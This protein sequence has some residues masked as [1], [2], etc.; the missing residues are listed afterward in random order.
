MSLIVCP[1]CGANVSSLAAKCP[2]CGCVISD[3]VQDQIAAKG[4]GY[5]DRPITS[6]DFE[7]NDFSL[8]T[9]DK[10][11]LIP[12]SSIASLVLG[13]MS[14]TQSCMALGGFSAMADMC[15]HDEILVCFV[16]IAIFAVIGFILGL[17][18]KSKASKASDIY[19]KNKQ[20]YK[21][22]GLFTVGKATSIAGFVS[23]LVLFAIGLLV[24]AAI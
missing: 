20:Q 5:V 17:V 12:P 4:S 19:S 18:G 22:P 16:F 1:E 15:R 14:I 6:T 7:M 9:P 13:C 10:A 2:K 21:L 3:S 23:S 8:E 11:K 24:V